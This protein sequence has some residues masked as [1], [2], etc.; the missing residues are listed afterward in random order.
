MLPAD[1]F[2][3]IDQCMTS[4]SLRATRKVQA[5]RMVAEKEPERLKQIEAIREQATMLHACRLNRDKVTE[6]SVA[7]SMREAV[8][9]YVAAVDQDIADG[10]DPDAAREWKERAQE[11]VN[12]TNLDMPVAGTD[13]EEPA[14]APREVPAPK[15]QEGATDYLAPL[16]G[17]IEQAR[18]IA[19]AANR[20]LNDPE[21]AVLRGFGKQL[22]GSR[23]E[24]L[25]LSRSLVVGQP[26]GVAAEATRL[27]DEA[28]ENIRISREL[29]RAALRDMGAASDISEASGPAR[30]RPAAQGG[31]LMGRR[32]VVPMP[33]GAQ[34]PPVREWEQ[35]PLFREWEQRPPPPSRLGAATPPCEVGL[36][37]YADRLGP[38][39]HTGQPTMGVAGVAAAAKDK[40]GGQ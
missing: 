31:P 15:P 39:I 17:A 34:R 26:A 22:G 27:A 36:G 37:G 8:T 30:A 35:R 10:L 12:L 29:I 13:G 32:P 3:V 7:K 2:R 19:N 28:C 14:L 40:G 20:E 11:I 38:P 24:I 4:L 1:V 6:E 18:L 23:K 21:E 9:E 25:A 16:K 5:D 33:A